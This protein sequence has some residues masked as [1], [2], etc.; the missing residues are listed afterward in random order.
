MVG[1]SHPELLGPFREKHSERPEEFRM[2]ILLPHNYVNTQLIYVNIQYNHADKQHDFV[3]V[4]DYY[5]I[6]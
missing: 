2:G 3:S 6:M 5:V 1:Y 4:Q